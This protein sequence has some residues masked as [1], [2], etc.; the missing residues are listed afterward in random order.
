M[1]GNYGGYYMMQENRLN[2][3]RRL[4]ETSLMVGSTPDFMVQ[5]EIARQKRKASL[6]SDGWYSWDIENAQ[7]KGSKESPVFEI[8][9]SLSRHGECG[10]GYED[11]AAMIRLSADNPDV[12]NIGLKIDSPGGNVDG[13]KSVA[14]AIIYAKSKG[15]KVLA[16]GGFIASAA[17]YIASQCDEIWLDNQAAS[18]IGS[19]GVLFVHIDESGALEKA[20]LKVTI[21]RAPGSENK[22]KLNSI[23][24]ATPEIL[25][26]ELL[27][28]KDLRQEFVGYVRRGRRGKLTSAEWEDASMFRQK[29]ALRIG[30]ADKV[31][32]LYDFLDQLKQ[33]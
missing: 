22:A 32:S 5:A 1:I 30:L 26:P 7:R 28:L 23:E 3:Y 10:Y 21:H 2:A 18:E 15:K 4:A 24:P 29:D 11:Y 13:V 16:W 6:H 31:G 27:F 33:V 12:K 8:N 14:D 25:A 17:Y 20:G 19:I 9:G